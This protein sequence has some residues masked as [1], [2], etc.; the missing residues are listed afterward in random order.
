[1]IL[2]RSLNG[3]TRDSLELQGKLM[4]VDMAVQEAMK[5]VLSP[6]QLLI[7]E[8]KLTPWKISRPGLFG[9]GGKVIKTKYHSE[10]STENLNTWV[11]VLVLPNNCI[12][13]LIFL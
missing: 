12:N 5:F 1:M 8:E 4:S 3:Y 6:E 10:N 9:V 7:Y 13:Y 2:L 11:L